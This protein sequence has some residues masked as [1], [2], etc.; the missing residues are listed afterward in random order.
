MS[1]YY[2]ALRKMLRNVRLSCGFS[3]SAVSKAL[4][5][6]RSAYTYYETGKTSPDIPT[7]L[8]L[9]DVFSLPAEAF[10]HPED[11]ADL[12]TSRRRA[13]RRIE[14]DLSYIGS[15]RE[16]E[17]ALVACFRAEHIREEGQ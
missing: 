4:G 17:K 7:L 5:I 12:E 8:I 14:A 16:E 13:P 2:N 15:L 3:Q 11:F 9:A 6:T 10:L 1:D